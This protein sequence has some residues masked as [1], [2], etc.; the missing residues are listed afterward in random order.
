MKLV[1]MQQV[2]LK[3]FLVISTRM[4][5]VLLTRNVVLSSLWQCITKFFDGMFR[6]LLVLDKHV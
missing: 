1:N 4:L 2:T 5:N 6:L 3:L